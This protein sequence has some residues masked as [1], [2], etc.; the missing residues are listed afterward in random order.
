MT[1]SNSSDFYTD[2]LCRFNGTRGFVINFSLDGI[3]TFFGEEKFACDG[4]NPLRPFFDAARHPETN[5]FVMNVLIWY[6]SP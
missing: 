3:D 2:A 6:F 4:F 5:G 1:H